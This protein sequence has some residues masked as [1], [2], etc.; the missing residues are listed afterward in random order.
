MRRVLSTTNCP[1]EHRAN[2]GVLEDEAVSRSKFRLRLFLGVFIS[3]IVLGT[4]GFV[5]I[6]GKRPLDALYLSVATVST[7][8]YGD[9]HADSD[10]GKVLAILLIIVGV[11]AFL[12]VVA[13]SAELMLNRRERGV[14]F[15]KINM[16]SGVFYS[17]V[18]SKLLTMCA[19]ADP[20][21]ESIR[22]HL[23]L[24]PDWTNKDF[25]QVSRRLKS[26]ECAIAVPRVDLPALRELLTGKRSCLVA[27]LENPVLL[28]SESF[29][30]MLQAVFHLSE[31]LASRD[32]LND[33]P[34][35]DR[36]HLAGDIKRAYAA[37]V[38]QWLDH[39]R[40][41]KTH[42]PYLFSL[43]MRMNPFDLN[44]TAVIGKKD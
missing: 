33:L 39:M 29:T 6:D 9:V 44:R 1:Y 43:A 23:L 16:L 11:G 21:I 14:R 10:A 4:A 13:S 20:D 2:H 18:G 7:V 38:K 25:A 22:E 26:H 42:Y 8:G 31:E 32:S 36:T 19:E 15:N 5:F 12:E 41:L 24:N 27:L 3:A 40:Y 35:D 37:L 17:E 34:E 28:E 30:A